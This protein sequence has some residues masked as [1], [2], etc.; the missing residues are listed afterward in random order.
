MISAFFV[1]EF[2]PI[3]SL[4][5]CFISLAVNFGENHFDLKANEYSFQA[6]FASELV[7]QF[8]VDGKYVY[9]D[10]QFYK[11]SFRK[12]L[13]KDRKDIQKNTIYDILLGDSIRP[14]IVIPYGNT[15]DARYTDTRETKYYTI[16]KET[17]NNPKDKAMD[18][19][20]ADKDILAQLSIISELK[21]TAS[22]KN[23][24]IAMIIKDLLKLSIFSASFFKIKTELRRIEHKLIPVMII[25]DNDDRIKN[26][27]VKLSQLISSLRKINDELSIQASDYLHPIVF[28]IK[29]NESGIE[30]KLYSYNINEYKYELSI[31]KSEE[32]ILHCKSLLNLTT[33][34]VSSD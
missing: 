1:T 31:I 13:G 23:Q 4:P 26:I 21:V 16:E 19:R 18:L 14:D 20:K 7:N 25:L 34:V 5:S 32:D 9:R 11:E 29:K 17:K 2:L 30:H 12:V 8:S 24:K 10:I 3:S 22:V 15:I 27:E 33:P 28:L 6:W